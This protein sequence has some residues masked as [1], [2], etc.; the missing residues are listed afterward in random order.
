MP[1]RNRPCSA[2]V[3]F[4]YYM[5]EAVLENTLATQHFPLSGLPD[6]SGNTYKPTCSPGTA[7]SSLW[8]SAPATLVDSENSQG[9]NMEPPAYFLASKTARKRPD[10]AT[11]WYSASLD[12]RNSGE[13]ILWKTRVGLPVL[14]LSTSFYD[15]CCIYGA[16]EDTPYNPEFTPTHDFK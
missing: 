10:F 5:G 13:P 11:S 6:Y 14:L 16:Q 15:I 3:S 9:G 4:A 12:N 2:G 1:M 8:I 7:M